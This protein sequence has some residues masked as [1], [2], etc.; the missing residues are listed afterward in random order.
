MLRGLAFTCECF[1]FLVG[2]K[3][4]PIWRTQHWSDDDRRHH[5][6]PFFPSALANFAGPR[7]LQ[8]LPFSTLDTGCS[9]GQGFGNEKFPDLD[10]EFASFL[11]LWSCDWAC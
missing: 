8:E 5:R 7:D 2:V 4:R 1:C 3:T 10:M 9:N 6:L 11:G